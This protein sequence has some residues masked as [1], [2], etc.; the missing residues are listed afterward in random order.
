MKAR[1]NNN[2]YEIKFEN[3]KNNSGVISGKS[4]ETD[5]LPVDSNTYHLIRNLKSYT[6]EVLDINT[7]E[8]NVTLKVNGNK[9]QANIEDELDEFLKKLGIKNKTN[10]KPKDLK[11]P[12]PGLVTQ[13]N[14]SAGDILK[15]GDLV[16]ILEAMKMENNI[17]I[18]F[19][20]V[21][22]EV[23]TEKGK[24]VEKNQILVVFE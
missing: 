5:V 23:K 13:V 19:D 16:L 15:K 22:K 14:V 21:V 24:T 9:Y 8:K 18:D 3:N 11:A 20:A 6:I 4:F 7:H 1:I 2:E 12:M 10:Q 17:K